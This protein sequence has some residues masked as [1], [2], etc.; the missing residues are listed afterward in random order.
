MTWPT[1]LALAA[2]IGLFATS[3][4][5]G[6]QPEPTA[7]RAKPEETPAPAPF[8]IAASSPTANKPPTPIFLV[9]MDTLRS[10]SLL[11][12]RDA[13]LPP[14]ALKRLILDSIFYERAYAPSSWTRT[15]VATLLTGL[16]PHGHRVYDRLH[17]L[18]ETLVT[19]PEL[20]RDAGYRTH[21][22]STNP[23]ILPLWGFAQGFDT[24]VEVPWSEKGKPQADQVFDLVEAAVASQGPEPAFYYIHLMDPHHPYDPDPKLLEQAGRSASVRNRNKTDGSRRAYKTYMAEIAKME[25]RIGEFLE[26][27]EERGLYD[28]ALILL[29]SDHGEEFREHGGRRHGRT[30]YEEVLRV[31]LFLKL[32][33][34]RNGGTIRS[35]A[36]ALADV[37]PTLLEAAG[38]P[39]PEGLRGQSLAAGPKGDRPMTGVLYMDERELESVMHDGWKLIRSSDGTEELYALAEDRGE[40]ENRAEEEP[41]RAD[42]LR[43]L[44]EAK[45]ALDRYGWRILACPG[46]RQGTLRFALRTNGTVGYLDL[47]E[48]DRVDNPSGERLEVSLE[49]TGPDL[50]TLTATRPTLDGDLHDVIGDMDGLSIRGDDDQTTIESIDDDPIRYRVAN[51]EIRTAH[52]PLSLGKLKAAATIGPL[53]RVRCPRRADAQPFLSL[54]YVPAPS[55]VDRQQVDEDL[56]ERLKLLG[57]QW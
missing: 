35:E 7:I 50:D 17:K 8:E 48:D 5:A 29:T 28:P 22:W 9:L 46:A 19:L 41:A 51:A 30:L 37:T 13:I 26:F 36:A 34:T 20:L 16:E 44:M 1:R 4:T 53:E 15:S 3:C 49:V 33:H 23:N 31:P 2:A 38:L 55:V 21:A 32:P 39:L 57:Y 14:K 11:G 43:A 52:S 18:D 25:R 12:T 45:S 10:D 56:V 27:L 6:D 47:E 24:F 54:S 42:S 40:R